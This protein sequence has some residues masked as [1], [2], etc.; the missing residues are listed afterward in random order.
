MI[1]LSTRQEIQGFRVSTRLVLQPGQPIGHIIL[2]RILLV[3]PHQDP[4]GLLRAIR[5]ERIHR[6]SQ[7]LAKSRNLRG[8][9]GG[10]QEHE[11]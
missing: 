5:V 7:G 10:S 3:Q 2:P 4:G 11:E 9:Q 1:P 6:S 8:S